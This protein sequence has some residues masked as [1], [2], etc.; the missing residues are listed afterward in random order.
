MASGPSVRLRITL[1]AQL[2]RPPSGVLTKPD[3]IPS[4]EEHHWISFIKNE[5]EP[6]EH[7]WFSVKQPSSHELKQGITWAEARQSENNFFSSTPPW[8]EM[9][10]MYQKYLRTTNLIKRL[11]D[12]LSDLV[13]K[14]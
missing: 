3:R 11:S 12:I 7:N 13:A 2:L 8:S 14:R 5:K 1:S 10:A 9:D 6:L 4:G